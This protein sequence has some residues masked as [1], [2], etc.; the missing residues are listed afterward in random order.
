MKTLIADDHVLFR[1]GLK[2]I[3]AAEFEAATFGEAGD[4]PHLLELVRREHWD[5]L[6]LD[7]TMPGRSGLDALKE[8]RQLR[9]ELPVLVLSMHPEDQFGLRAFRMGAAGYI[10]K[11]C[12]AEQLFEAIHRVTNGHKYVSPWLAEQLATALQARTPEPTH[13]SLSDRELEVMLLI[14]G[15]KSVKEVASELC[16]SV[17]TISTHR[18]HILK[19][20]H[21]HN[22]SEIMRYAFQHGL[23]S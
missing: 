16:L 6:L 3:L 14:A 21:L 22:N 19:K 11:T 18:E 20:L 4:V 2:G 5:L 15:G 10:T 12:A 13:E 8:I 23:V 17:K 7:I 9:P 1:Q